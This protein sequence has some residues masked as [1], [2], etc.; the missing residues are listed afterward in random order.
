MN[1]KKQE[2][3]A[4]RDNDGRNFILDKINDPEFIKGFGHY[5]KI[6][7]NLILPKYQDV[8]YSKSSSVDVGELICSQKKFLKQRLDKSLNPVGDGV[9]FLVPLA[10]IM[11]LPPNYQ[12]NRVLPVKKMFS[13]RLSSDKLLTITL[14]TGMQNHGDDNNGGK[15][16]SGMCFALLGYRT[17]GRLKPKQFG[18]IY[19]ACVAYLNDFIT[20]YKLFRHDH[21]ISN[22]TPRTLPGRVEYFHDTSSGLSTKRI[23]RVH[24]NEI[25]DL[26]SKRL[27][28][29]EEMQSIELLTEYLPADKTAHYALRI[30]EQS[31]TNLCLGQFEDCILNSDRFTE[32]VLREVLRK[33]LGLKDS[34]MNKYRNLYSTQYPNSA[35]VQVLADKFNIK[36]N[37]II[38]NWFRKSR[39]VRNNIIHKLDFESISP[40]IAKEAI[41][42][43]MRIINLVTSNASG[44]FDWYKIIPDTFSKLFLNGK[45]MET[46]KRK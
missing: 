17:N 33:E 20:A 10:S 12:S 38:T 4:K 14:I 28:F 27:P 34:E 32:L 23:M 41:E 30:G 7:D 8:I 40:E 9:Y 18:D 29:K 46:K 25:T 6:N 13:K 21:T 43:N 36:G 19:Q 22:V 45:P 3:M 42:Y 1:N 11:A 5:M 15:L 26:W 39:E 37:A 44:N 16:W 2:R 35:V 24:D 31:I